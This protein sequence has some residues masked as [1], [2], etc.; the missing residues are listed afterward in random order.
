MTRCHWS[1]IILIMSVN[2]KNKKLRN[3]LA[4][5]KKDIQEFKRKR[6]YAR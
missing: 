1:V 4:D 6:E 3:G 5:K 2:S